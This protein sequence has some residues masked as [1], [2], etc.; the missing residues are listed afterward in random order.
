MNRSLHTVSLRIPGEWRDAWLYREYLYLWDNDGGIIRVPVDTIQRE[1]SE[2]GPSR[3]LLIDNLIFRN[4][5]KHAEQFRRWVHLRGARNA[6]LDEHANDVY[7]EIHVGASALKVNTDSVPG[8]LLD[9]NIYGNRLFSATESGLYETFLPPQRF[10]EEYHP[11]L[12][13]M[14]TRVFGVDARGSRIVAAAGEQGL[15]ERRINLGDGEAWA[16]QAAEQRAVRIDD[17]SRRASF[18]NYSVLNY[19]GDPNPS[20]IRT[21]TSTTTNE[22]S[23]FSETLVDGFEQPTSI[24]EKLE[25]VMGDTELDANRVYGNSGNRLLVANRR[26]ARVVNLYTDTNHEV[27]LSENRYF[28]ETAI[29]HTKITSSLATYRLRSGFLLEMFSGVNLITTSGSYDV[30]TEPCLRIRTF[31][32]SRR[33][34]DAFAAISENYVDL[35]GFL[36]TPPV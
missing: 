11:L 22:R 19:K 16:T 36:E 17:Y 4:D 30:Y 27:R 3:A 14:E 5:W 31:P 23:G 25:A 29:D 35:V 32:A 10:S 6:L 12:P 34:F 7:H 24:D 8:Y 13:I 18:A 9:C 33:Y 15:F 26:H 20:L 28:R 1:T 2:L 21:H